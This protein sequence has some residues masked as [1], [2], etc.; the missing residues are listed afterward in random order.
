[1]VCSLT[2]LPKRF[3]RLDV[4]LIKRSVY[5]FHLFSGFVCVSLSVSVSS[6]SHWPQCFFP[7][8]M[9]A[10]CFGGLMLRLNVVV[11]NGVTIPVYSSILL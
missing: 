1:M 6:F 9:P 5:Y 3:H 10:M 7:S 2:F 4:D 11:F 8:G